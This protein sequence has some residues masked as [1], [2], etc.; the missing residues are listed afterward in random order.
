MPAPVADPTVRLWRNNGC[1][2]WDAVISAAL[3]SILHQLYNKAKFAAGDW[4]QQDEP[5][6]GAGTWFLA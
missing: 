1:T 2:A 5:A 6:T 4:L 3:I